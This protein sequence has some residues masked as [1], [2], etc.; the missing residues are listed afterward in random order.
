MKINNIHSN[1]LRKN[2][3]YWGIILMLLNV[4]YV[5]AQKKISQWDEDLSELLAKIERIHPDPFHHITKE[6]FYKTAKDVQTSFTNDSIGNQIKMLKLVSLLR[7][8]HTALYPN[9]GFV[10]WLPLSIYKF[11]DGFYVISAIQKYK[12]ILGAKII[13]FENAS[14]SKV[15]E[16]TADLHSSDNNVGRQLNTYYMS[17]M[18]VLSYYNFVDNKKNIILN[19]LL[20]NGI[21]KEIKIESVDISRRLNVVLD[22]PEFFGPMN[23][24]IYP[25]YV[26]AYK[27]LNIKDYYSQPLGGK[28]D[29]PQFLR[30]RKGYW[31]EYIAAH[32]AMYIAICFSTNDSR[33][34]FED[35]NSFLKEVFSK[36]DVNPIEKVIL[37]IRFNPGGDGSITLPL[38]HEFIKRDS[39]NKKGKLF[40]LTGRKTYSAAQMIYAEMLE[41]TNTLLVGEPAGAPVNGYGDPSSFILTNSKMNYQI[42]TLYWQLGHPGDTSRVQKIDIPF[43][44]KGEDYINGKDQALEYILSMDGEYLSL[45]KILKDY[46]I[47]VFKKEYSNRRKQFGTYSWW[48]PFDE[49]EMRHTARNLF[50]NGFREKGYTGFEALIDCYPDSWRAFRDYAQRTI[51]AKDY[52]RAKNLVKRGL[53]INPA[54]SD[55][56]E[57]M[58]IIQQS[59]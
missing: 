3:I 32:N 46:S 10:N 56:K 24:Q 52:E 44:F 2:G 37:D 55:L 16:I 45:P 4:N 14:A 39:I 30:N 41:H 28:M 47:E 50:D 48:N 40:T 31:Y 7:D 53:K 17:S 11:E 6:A 42:S 13:S 26:F 58:T 21:Q 18:D 19:V 5:G 33:N 15:F 27:G 49:G 29:I 25:D 1:T 8:R 54:S 38:V 20:P 59:H 35:F 12:E 43:V 36:I 57:L 51:E 22:H 34:G 23:E 9:K